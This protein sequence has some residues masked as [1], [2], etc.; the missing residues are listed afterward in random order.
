MIT[1]SQKILK[2]EGEM[3]KAL[4][5]AL[6]SAVIAALGA[7]SANALTLSSSSGSLP[8]APGTNG[9]EYKIA[10]EVYSNTAGVSTSSS[11]GII[12]L[13]LASSVNPGETINLVISNGVA[14]FN[15]GGA[16]NY[17]ALVYDSD[18]DNNYYDEI[19]N[20]TGSDADG[21]GS[22]AE[23]G[24]VAMVPSPGLVTD[25]L[26]FNVSANF[27]PGRLRLVL[28]NDAD[29]SGTINAGDSIVD[30]DGLYGADGAGLYVHPGLNADCT[31]RPT[32][33]MTA[34]TPHET[35]ATPVTFAII[36]PQYSVSINNTALNAEL[37]SDTDFATFT[38]LFT[39]PYVSPTTIN[40]ATGTGTY[41]IT[42][43]SASNPAMWIAWDTMGSFSATYTLASLTP[44]PGIVSITPSGG[45]CT[46]DTANQNWSCSETASV[47]ANSHTIILDG[48][49]SNFP[50]Q[51]TLENLSITSLGL[52]P[53]CVPGDTTVGV[54]MGGLE[55]FVPF[56][57]SDAA[58]GYET[59][60]VLY[61]RYDKDV[62]V[63]VT[64][65]ADSGATR[66]MVAYKQIPGKE[67]I[68]AS[69]K[70]VI[71]GEDIANFLSANGI[72]YDMAEG[73][74]VKFQLRVPS[75]M[76]PSGVYGQDVYFTGNPAP[77]ATTTPGRVINP[78]DPYVEGI[79]I[80]TYPGGQR[81]IPLKF[82]WFKNGE[83]NQ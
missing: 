50:T 62:P 72:N 70:L 64:T 32:V 60:I 28:I 15:A 10:Y 61:N 7:G 49:T 23:N 40:S 83:Y 68:P 77:V 56:V 9:N 5:A 39:P 29:G 46:P 73:I 47:G 52:N 69:G 37:D 4:K 33:E 71:T 82:K 80:S 12:Y 8:A 59:Y 20:L 34:S 19:D 2:K 3:R 17:F 25:N 43:Q 76:G 30:Q 79:V 57:K 35:T 42:D 24:L 36:E 18:G 65:F 54:W 21:D 1:K 22:T 58:N 45:I 41:T 38:N 51:W 11:K 13:D 66:I 44:E 55:A 14:D 16:Q 26:N 27:G 31:N 67:V 6:F 78:N 63:Y 75:Q 48:T 74:P 53:L 81:S